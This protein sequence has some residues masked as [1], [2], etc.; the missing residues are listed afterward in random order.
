MVLDKKTTYC[1][2]GIL[3][4]QEGWYLTRGP[5]I[6]Q[7]GYYFSKKIVFY[8]ATRCCSEG[9]TIFPQEDSILQKDQMLF[10]GNYYFSQRI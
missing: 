3:F 7:R 4:F 8:K 1:S 6:A 10:R 9:I 2:E 5:H